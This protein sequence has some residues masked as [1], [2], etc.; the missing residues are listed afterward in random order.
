MYKKKK[1]KIAKLVIVMFFWVS[2][3]RNL[4]RLM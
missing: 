3:A 1:K 4:K 2:L